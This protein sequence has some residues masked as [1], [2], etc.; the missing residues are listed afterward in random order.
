MCDTILEFRHTKQV[1]W[2]WPDLTRTNLDNPKST[3]AHPIEGW[4][5]LAHVD[6]RVESG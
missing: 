6:G 3:R 4:V 1:L 5:R 2:A